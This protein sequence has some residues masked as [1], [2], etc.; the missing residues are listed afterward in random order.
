MRGEWIELSGTR[1]YV[2][3]WGA[4]GGRPLLFLHSLGPAASGA[5]LGPGIGPLV[6]GGFAIAAP[7]HPGF[8]QSPPVD[9]D[10][11]AVPRLADRAWAIADAL[12]W[13][14]LVL[15]GH[16]WGGSIAVHAAAARPARVRGLVLVDS[17]H[18]DYADQPEA[19][20]S[21]SLESLSAEAETARRRAPDRAGVAKDLELEP[22]DP[23]V[24][25]FLEGVMDDGQGGLISRTTGMSRGAAMYHL[26][27]ARQS[28]HWSAIADARIPTLLLLATKPDDIRTLNQAGAAR[29]REAVPQ[30]DIRFIAGATHSLITDLRDRF[31]ET[32]RDWLDVARRS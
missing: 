13:R 23:V 1:A 26:M 22:D 14:D 27:R 16:S 20:L 18:L 3:R 31:G 11:Y 4:D 8:G 25:A 21:K 24:T 10:A 5:L 12:G 29:F 19:D 2:R 7:D 28:D 9:P 6:D 17:G 15:S 32:V 30:A